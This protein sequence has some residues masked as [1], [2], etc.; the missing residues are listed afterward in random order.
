MAGTVTLE[1]YTIGN[2]R[3]VVATCVA[4]AADASFPDTVLPPI[5]G[6]LLSLATNPGGTAPTANY[7]VT[8]ENQ[9]GADVLQGVGAN[10][11]TSNTEQVPVLYSGTGTHPAVDESDTLTLK[12]AN[13]AVNGAQ[14]VVE[15]T[16]ALGG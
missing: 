14:T 6:R 15:L 16:Y 8:V 12:I 13:N 9:H 2:I 3:K 10:R 11:H 7:D 4:D 5:E 1:H